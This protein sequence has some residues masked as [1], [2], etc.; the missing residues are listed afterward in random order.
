MYY[1]FDTNNIFQDHRPNNFKPKNKNEL[2]LQLFYYDINVLFI[3]IYIYIYLYNT[4]F[5]ICTLLSL[6]CIFL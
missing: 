1:I 2:L 4:I 6:F 5:Y 3:F